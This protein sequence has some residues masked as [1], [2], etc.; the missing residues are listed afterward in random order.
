MH[1]PVNMTKDSWRGYWLVQACNEE[2][3]E[4]V[5]AV[6]VQLSHQTGTSFTE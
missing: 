4:N 2:K 1:V 3:I 5:G 6:Y